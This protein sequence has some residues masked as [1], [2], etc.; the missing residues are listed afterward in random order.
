MS[1]VMTF[2]M[3]SK[4]YT[5][6]DLEVDRVF[7]IKIGDLRARKGIK[8]KSF[9]IFVKKGTKDNEYIETERLK[10]KLQKAVKTK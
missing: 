2:K 8:Q 9:S 5:D 6:E 7:E 1:S 3:S 4:L 10:D